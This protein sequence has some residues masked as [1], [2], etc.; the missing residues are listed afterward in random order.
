MPEDRFLGGH[1]VEGAIVCSTGEFVLAEL[2]RIAMLR[3]VNEET[4]EFELN[5]RRSE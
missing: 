1:L 4:K 5:P 3:T 2:E